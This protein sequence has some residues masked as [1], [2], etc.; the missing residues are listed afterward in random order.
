MRAT[1]NNSAA[2]TLKNLKQYVDNK[3]NGSLVTMQRKNQSSKKKSKP[4]VSLVRHSP[5]D[6]LSHCAKKYFLACVDPFN[7]DADG[8]CVP[9]HP[10]RPS[11][12]LTTFNRVSF[13]C[14][15]SSSNPGSIGIVFIHP[16]LASDSPIATYYDGTFGFSSLPTREVLAFVSQFAL[17][18]N[19]NSPYTASQFITTKT[20]STV[21]AQVSGRIVSVG[22]SIQYFGAELYKG[23]GLISYVSPNHDSL[24]NVPLAEVGGYKESAVVRMADEEY[25]Q[26]TSGL[27]D[28][29]LT[30]QN[31]PAYGDSNNSS[32][33][34]PFSGGQTLSTPVDGMAAGTFTGSAS[35]VTAVSFVSTIKSGSFPATG[36]FSYFVQGTSTV[37]T[38]AYTAGSATQIGTGTTYTIA[39]TITA[40]TFTANK[41]FIS[42]SATATPPSSSNGQLSYAVGGA[43]MVF[44]LSTAG[45][46]SNTATFELEVCQ[47]VE[48][49]GRTIQASLTPT[50][51]DSRGFEL[52]STAVAR[53]PE[54]KANDPKKSILSLATTAL[55][56]VIYES[57]PMVTRALGSLALNA[58]NSYMSSPA[59]RHRMLRG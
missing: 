22:A 20:N 54:M 15:G 58:A 21:Q 52:V 43:P 8:A 2:S 18:I 30:Y 19:T 14:G 32:L 26:V 57:A 41:V 5:M 40:T 17:T 11:Q 36:T 25:W 24:Y 39:A 3:I 28:V 13:T 37:Q 7:P 46:S 33:I 34:Y 50:H 42:S 4:R 6:Q 51:S 44:L 55:Q 59:G 53:A 56:D 23:G 31:Y 16:C 35:S 49:I 27:D 12:K 45:S 10:S 29:E 38:V 9:R 1:Q 47:H 48:F